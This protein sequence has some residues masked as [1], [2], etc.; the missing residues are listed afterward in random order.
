MLP[1]F[2][3][4]SNSAV[5][6]VI[7]VLFL[8]A[9]LASFATQ[10]IQSVFSGGGFGRLSAGTLA[11]VGD[12]EVTD[13][14]VDSAMR[15]VLQQAQRQ[16]PEVT[17]STIAGQFEPVLEQL[18]TER[19]LLA[20]IEDNHFIVSKRLVDAQI[21]NLPQTQGLDGKFNEQAYAAFLQQQ[22][23]TD[24]E[25]RRVLQAAL[26]ERMILTPAAVDPRIPIGVARPYA[27]ML[28]EMREGQLGLV[29]TDA[30]RAGLN[31]SDG[32]LQSFYSQNRQRYTVPEQRV[33]RL[34][35]IS[36]EAVPA[37]TEAE[38][39]AYY[40]AN[41]ATYAGS[42]SRV[43]S[44]V[45]V[46]DKRQADGVAARAKAGAAFAA[47]AAPAGF[48]AEDVSLGAKT[49]AEFA[50]VA[51]DAVA[52]A[53]FSAAKGA[54]IG[55]IRSDLGWHVVKVE[56]VRGASGRSLAQV[57]GEIAALLKANKSKEVLTE[58][59]TRVEDQIADGASFNEAVSAAKLP[60]VTTPA[61]N[62]GG[63]SRTDRAYRLP[64]ELQPALKAGFAMS[65]EDDP[66]VVTLPDNAG[67]VLVA[68][69][70]VIAAAPAPLAQIKERV[71]ADWIQR[72]ASDRGRAVA[73]D[74]AA[75][76]GR[77]TPLDQ[78]MDQS[79]TPLPPVQPMSA[80]RIQISQANAEAAVPLR[81]L[82]TLAQGKSRMVADPKGRGFYIIKTDKITPGNATNNPLLI[83]QTQAE[84]QQ[85]AANELGEEMLAAMK[86][87][88][89][90]KRN[91]EAIAKSKRRITGADQ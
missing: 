36:A 82:F 58:L 89:T 33:L 90:V 28:L 27:S 64:A 76:V 20:F 5:G 50:G 15:R 73:A 77:G 87:E 43:I 53:V 37:P 80:R 68:L 16:N 29:P 71:R 8:L 34:A 60:V 61:I 32:D 24:A 88:L 86:A 3:R 25:L 11:K 40:K 7:M 62:S 18:I 46:Q 42:E 70:S 6:T 9:I 52:N 13:R 79:G 65:P 75:K 59:V 39:A 17:Y 26:T 83:A 74:V 84:F 35:K 67:Y 69:D 10:D 85:T 51:N 54:V 14:D 44:Q 41:Q 19:T 23:L 2:R 72:K 63:T 49:R 22:Q 48:A 12:E 45:V 81:M 57:H 4:L 66:E 1:V 47:A 56:D 78:A 55:P 30:F 31:P 38:I 21:A 91:E